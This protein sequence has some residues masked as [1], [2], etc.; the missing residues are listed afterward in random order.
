[1]ADGRGAWYT[2]TR[3][4]ALVMAV[5][6][7]V[8]LLAALASAIDLPDNEDER[9]QDTRDQTA[10]DQEAAAQ[11][12]GGQAGAGGKSEAG[13]AGGAGG[14]GSLN[15]GASGRIDI[16]DG[17][18]FDVQ[19]L[20]GCAGG[21]A[22]GDD[23]LIVPDPEA[24]GFEPLPPGATGFESSGKRILVPDVDGDIGGF[25]LGPDGIELVGP[26]ELGASDFV[27]GLL[28]DGSFG[29]IRPDGSAVEIV[30]GD[31]GLILR[32]PERGS[33]DFV[34]GPGSA[35]DTE[36]PSFNPGQVPPALTEPDDGDSD[37]RAD[38][39]T[40]SDEPGFPVVLIA[41]VAAAIALAVGL[42]FWRKHTAQQPQS[43]ATNGASS[44]DNLALEINALD[45]LL[46]EIEQEPD[47]RVAIRK[48]YSAL[49]SGLGN[50]AMARRPPETPGVFLQRLLGRFDDVQ[51][52]NQLQELVVLFEHARFSEH[53][54]TGD[55]RDRAVRA[56]GEI[57]GRY[58]NAASELSTPLVV[59]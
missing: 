12:G 29:L 57:R 39:D 37:S 55:M 59:A 32:D 17:Q 47:P 10:A 18:G 56:L 40:E 16:G 43:S 7:G 45:R 19:P 54:I 26:A 2:N 25:R 4:L 42:W 35:F 13:G 41:I 20:P 34:P 30:P 21:F 51:L 27:I 11:E 15:G 5:S 53:E 52:H 31:D 38:P 58:A 22:L 8:L 23:I 46:W 6:I 14:S 44:A 48:A 1:M 49:E 24:C 50:A 36:N 9:N 28:P 33:I 3:T